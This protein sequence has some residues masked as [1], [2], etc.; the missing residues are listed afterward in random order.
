MN[1]GNMRRWLLPGALVMASLLGTACQREKARW[2]EEVPKAG[3]PYQGIANDAQPLSSFGPGTGGAGT[4]H[5]APVQ[6]RVGENLPPT[7][8][9]NVPPRLE[10]G[11]A[12]GDP[13]AI[14]KFQQEEQKQAEEL[15]P[16]Q[17]QPKP[18]QKTNPGQTH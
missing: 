8:V 5:I 2:R 11:I 15:Q 4:P 13:D 16:A 6:D 9:D 10:P 12:A 3:G 14:L 7:A 1:Q 18:S 17:G